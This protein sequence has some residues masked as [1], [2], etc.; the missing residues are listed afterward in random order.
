MKHSYKIFLLGVCGIFAFLT[1]NAQDPHFTQF[2]ANPLYLNPALAG[3]KICPRVNISYRMQWPG[4]YG[5]YSTIGVS[6]DRLAYK[7]KGGIGMVIMNDNAGKGTLKTTGI[8]LIYAPTVPLTRKISATAAIQAGYWQKSVD[9]SKLNFGDQI[10]PQRGFTLPTQEVP[11]A[12]SAGNFDLSAGILVA[13]KNL[14]AGAAVHHILEQNESLMEGTSKL[15]RKYTVH[16]GANIPVSKASRYED[17]TVI[18]PNILYMQQ[19]D[20]HQLNLGMYVR[21]GT[22]VGGLWYRGD[23]SFIVLLGM[24]VNQLRLGYSY[25]VTVSK[26]TNASAGSHEITLGYQLACKKPPTKYRLVNCPG[27]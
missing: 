16:A 21:K 13:S 2:Y 6:M 4:I 12:Q 19:G 14:F 9:W 1:A 20:F 17:E 5:T 11:G 7:V 10:D 23:D 3:N 24:E 8:G 26:L 15:P 22:I 27:W 25:D 18:S